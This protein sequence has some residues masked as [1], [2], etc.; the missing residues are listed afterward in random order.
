MKDKTAMRAL[1]K[2]WRTRKDRVYAILALL[3]SMALIFVFVYF[4]IG[5]NTVVAFSNWHGL[6]QDLSFNGLKNF[7]ELFQNER[8][9]IG[10]RNMGVFA[11]AF[12]A[13]CIV[14]GFTVALLL[15]Q[16]LKWESFFRNLYI[17]PLAV[18]LVVTGVIWRW[19]MTP[20]S[21]QTGWVGIN[22]L[23]NYLGLD[24][25]KSGWH[26]NEHFGIIAVAIAA[27]WQMSGYVMAMYLAAMR[28]IP[29]ELKEAAVIDGASNFQYTARVVI[30][31][32]RTTTLSAIVILGHISLRVFDLVASMTGP[33]KGFITDVPAYYMWQTTFQGN[34]FNRGAAIALVLLV[35]VSALVVPY[36]LRTYKKSDDRSG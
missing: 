24:F 7:I 30:P 10:M 14:I 12:I 9:Q 34:R 11:L 1:G 26:T 6:R 16:N 27:T 35:L 8:F 29:L 31:L 25:L 36:I 13:G 2:S 17:Y 28:S 20:G 32:V 15:N 22:Q 3:P 18:S 4:L 33:G 19:L 21:E 5:W 23:F